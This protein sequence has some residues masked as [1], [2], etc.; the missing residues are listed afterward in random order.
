MEGRREERK[1][2]KVLKHEGVRDKRRISS[3]FFS[4]S[5]E[6]KMAPSQRAAHPPVSVL[7]PTG[8]SGSHALMAAIPLSTL[9]PYPGAGSAAP[10][11]EALLCP[12]G[13]Q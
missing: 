7:L 13:Q 5:K 2:E 3:S 6:G 4:L 9:P 1:Q 12:K 10:C 11:P 8:A